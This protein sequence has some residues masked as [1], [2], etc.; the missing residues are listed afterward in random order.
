MHSSDTFNDVPHSHGNHQ[1]DLIANLKV[2][3]RSTYINRFNEW[4]HFGSGSCD[5][6]HGYSSRQPLQFLI[7]RM[8]PSK[9]FSSSDIESWT[10]I[11]YCSSG[12]IFTTVER[13]ASIGKPTE[14]SQDISRLPVEAQFSDP[15]RICAR[16]FHVEQIFRINSLCPALTKLNPTAV[17][18]YPVAWPFPP[19]SNALT[20]GKLI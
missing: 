4:D 6:T 11:E 3:A 19:Q 18:S 8:L 12:F 13:Q 7:K 5:P 14:G 20:T 16:N 9:T 1:S 10:E 2:E 17:S 15:N